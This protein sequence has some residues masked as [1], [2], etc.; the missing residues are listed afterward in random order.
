M[1]GGGQ[2]PLSG[3]APKVRQ[4]CRVIASAAGN[5]KRADAVCGG[6]LLPW[7]VCSA[8]LMHDRLSD[9]QVADHRFSIDF[10][11]GKKSSFACDR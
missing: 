8:I 3:E 4:R 11:L 5:E 9:Q 6:V 10:E 7:E 1:G 2:H